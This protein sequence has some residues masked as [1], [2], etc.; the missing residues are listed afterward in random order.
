LLRKPRCTPFLKENYYL[1]PWLASLPIGERLK[2]SGRKLLLHGVRS[3][4]K[5]RSTSLS[6]FFLKV[7]FAIC[8]LKFAI[9]KL[10]GASPLRKRNW[11][12][13]TLLPNFNLQSTICNLQLQAFFL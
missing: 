8:N 13:V 4:L 6:P 7:Q 10:H 1:L 11:L 3:S 5:T 2:V 12:A 9:L